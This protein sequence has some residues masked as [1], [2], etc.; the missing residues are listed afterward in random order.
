MAMYTT[1]E[2]AAKLGLDGEYVRQMCRKQPDFRTGRSLHLPKGWEAKKFGATWMIYRVTKKHCPTSDPFPTHDPKVQDAYTA[3]GL[4]A[5]AS[6]DQVLE[7]HKFMVMAYHPDR[8]PE[9]GKARAEQE[10]KCVNHARDI[11][12]AHLS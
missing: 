10:L 11:L 7:R 4:P 9:V 12:K 1:K 8:F 3:L 6:L 5:G 2:F